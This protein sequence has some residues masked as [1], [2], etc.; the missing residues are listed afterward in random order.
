MCAEKAG[1][2]KHI[3]F[4]DCRMTCATNFMINGMER[5]ALMKFMGHINFNTTLRYIK[6]NSIISKE[7]EDKIEV[8]KVNKTLI[9]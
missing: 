2:K 1:I 5:Y 3:T 8:V 4:H 9:K 6:W 7:F